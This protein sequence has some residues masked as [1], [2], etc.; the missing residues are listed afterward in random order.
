MTEYSIIKLNKGEYLYEKG[1]D[2]NSISL[3][4]EGRIEAYSSYGVINFEKNNIAGLTD[5]LYGICIYD[6]IAAEDAVVHRFAYS[7]ESD[8]SGVIGA[9][10]DSGD[11]VMADN[12]YVMELIRIYLSLLIKCR[13]KSPAFSPDN[14]VSRWEIDKYNGLSSA[15]AGILRSYYNS[16]ISLAVAA[17]AENSRFANLLHNTC[18]QMGDMLNI[19]MSYS[20]PV[21]TAAVTA[22]APSQVIQS[23]GDIES[24]RE[25]LK[26]SMGKILRYAELM[27]ED[28]DNFIALISRFKNCRDRLS[29][30]ESIRRLRKS[31]SDSFYRIYD[32]IFSKAVTD[33]AIPIHIN[34]FLNF[35]YLDEE[36][37]GEENSVFLYRLAGNVDNLCNTGNVC[38][39]FHRLKQIL[40]GDKNPG[41]NV[42]D[43]SYSEYIRQEIK[44]GRLDI[45]EE[46][47][48]KDNER[49]VRFETDNL[50]HHANT[51]TNGRISVFVPI[52]IR[53]QV[54]RPLSDAFISAEG[55]MNIINGIRETDF[56]L[57]YRSVIYHND[58]AGISKEF[59]QKEVLPEIVLTPCAGTNALLWQD[60]DGRLRDTPAL[61]AFPIFCME[62]HETVV[63]NVLGRYR[64]E[65]C[66]RIQGTYWNDI[67]EKSLTSE[68]Y[69]YMLFY[70]KN[71]D[72]TD[73]AK[74]KIKSSLI[75]CR[76]NYSEVFA[77]D[78]AS[79]II[80]EARGNGK[81]NKIARNIFAKY[82]P[83]RKDVRDKLA[84]NPMFTDAVAGYDRV[85]AS[86][87]RRINNLCKSLTA[88]GIPVPEELET[89]RKLYDM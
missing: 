71:K 33:D 32:R 72:L 85:S 47:A 50:F 67:S 9:C 5:C 74:E 37:A 46:E 12:R 56:S 73:A 13:K 89:T 28:A 49:K 55:I 87:R 15:G 29:N 7:S 80:Y 34:M 18:M 21:M 51:I 44:C 86:V 16:G 38:T 4:I 27:R 75:N 20:P 26:N 3:I 62:N 10:P 79:W 24:I 1:N 77:R 58:K 25:D 11:I 53:E 54:L 19:D 17:L 81:L 66:K 52:L 42:L 31:I 8:L 23:E 22:P 68:Y 60:I 83:F 41:R 61:M 65:I 63:L 14:E 45:T 2:I 78:Y 69:D 43:Q 40:W 84:S 70:R 88:N 64:W 30:D 6:Y 39:I 48:L 59:I 35:G 76:N 36:L 57:F 82:C